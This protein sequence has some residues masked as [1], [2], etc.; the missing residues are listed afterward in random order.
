MRFLIC[1]LVIYWN[2]LI[3]NLS[4]F[5][6]VQKIGQ[7]GKFLYIFFFFAVEIFREGGL[8]LRQMSLRSPFRLLMAG[9]LVS[10]LPGSLLSESRTFA[11]LNLLPFYVQ[12][13][14]ILYMV[15]KLLNHSQDRDEGK[16]LIANLLFY[17]TLLHI[18][19]GLSVVLLAK[20]PLW[21][22]EWFGDHYRIGFGGNMG[23]RNQFGLLAAAGFGLGMWILSLRNLRDRFRFLLWIQCG[24]YLFLTVLSGTRGP[25]LFVVIIIGAAAYFRCKE[26]FAKTSH[27]LILLM[28]PTLLV[29]TFSG[30]L[31]LTSDR[32]SYEFL[33]V[34]F[35]GRVFIWAISWVRFLE[36][37]IL[38]GQGFRVIGES[39]LEL[40]R[41]ES[42]YFQSID[43]LS[44][45]SSY[46]EFLTSG[47]FLAFSIFLAL[48]VFLVRESRGQERCFL[49]AMFLLAGIESLLI[50]P[51]TPISFLFFVVVAGIIDRGFP[52]DRTVRKEIGA[53]C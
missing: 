2:L 44:L 27:L 41:P 49:L 1:S 9:F 31:L 42:E 38:F 40:Y 14:F 19:I 52:N 32:L 43:R 15:Q 48:A 25:V 47:G 4:S 17:S 23:D 7:W 35:S 3:L 16:L 30:W 26:R 13:L 8:L 21:E 36:G 6:E 45:H 24:F 37:N 50:L 34:I 22:V 53:R 10:L 28:L 11:L 46:V 5:S 20:L 51:N 18:G 39:L 12:I 33:N 29:M